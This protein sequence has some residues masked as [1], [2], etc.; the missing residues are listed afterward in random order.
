MCQFLLLRHN[1]RE[2]IFQGWN[3]FSVSL[4]YCLSLWYFHPFVLCILY[5]YTH[6]YHPPFSGFPIILLS[7]IFP[8]S[9]PPALKFCLFLSFPLSPL[10]VFPGEQTHWSLRFWLPL[11]NLTS[12]FQSTDFKWQSC[13]LYGETKHHSWFI[14]Y[15][16]YLIIGHLG[17]LHE[18]AIVDRVTANV[19]VQVS[20][21]YRRRL[22]KYISWRGISRS[23]HGG[24]TSLCS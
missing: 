9:L 2:V 20:V 12:S 6:S 22:P 10:K 19:D 13:V 21:V 5:I 14:P 1:S 7:S 15:C 17:W 3:H 23:N 16:L 8:N 11:L 18:L 4:T 24:K